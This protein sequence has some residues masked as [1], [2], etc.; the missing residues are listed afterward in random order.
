[1]S[2]MLWTPRLSLTDWAAILHCLAHIFLFFVVVLGLVV[3]VVLLL[4]LID[5]IGSNYPT[6][7]NQA[8]PTGQVTDKSTCAYLTADGRDNGLSVALTENVDYDNVF[9][10]SYDSGDMQYGRH[11]S[12]GNQNLIYWKGTKNF[13]DGCAAHIKHGY[14]AAGNMALPDHGTF[15]MEDTVFGPG[16]SFEANH[17]CGIGTTGDLC[18]PQYVF[19]NSTWSD[20]SGG[21]MSFQ[22]DGTK[23]HNPGALFVLAPPEEANLS[24]NIFPAGYCSLVSK[25][26]S[27]LLQHGGTSSADK[28]C[29]LST[30]SRFDNGILCKR[31]VRAIRI[32][33]RNIDAT[34][35]KKVK[36]ELFHQSDAT[37]ALATFLVPFQATEG[38]PAKK[39][40]YAFPV[41]TGLD[42]TY[43]LSLEGGSDL[44]A[45]WIIE[46]SDP[47]IGNRWTPDQIRLVVAGRTCPAITTSQHDRVWLTGPMPMDGPQGPPSE[48]WGRGACKAHAD[49]PN[50][51]CATTPALALNECPSACPGGCSNGWCDCGTKQCVCDPGFQGASCEVDVGATGRCGSHGRYSGRFLGGTFPPTAQ[52]CICEPG[53][54]TGPLCDRN[55]C[56]EAGEKGK[57]GGHGTCVAVG[58]NGF[59]CDCD[60]GYSGA[61]CET[62]CA[63]WSVRG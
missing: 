61:S 2:S 41:I 29:T 44:P 62:T 1:M 43:K 25:F 19:S 6:K 30:S 48:A 33:S 63:T 23:Y 32:Y 11:V 24:G 57:C 13:A 7:T 10:G 46:F 36:L 58:A 3:V 20:A 49:M 16:V 55:P 35:A 26:H 21:R 4:L 14:F 34:T 56:A 40:G 53:G 59:R 52:T 42:H 37:N 8:L 60:Q 27:W 38:S 50:V 12:L 5:F 15:I 18:M 22:Q 17:H 31:P 47:V 28:T 9:V 54:W 51:D 45:D 39:Q